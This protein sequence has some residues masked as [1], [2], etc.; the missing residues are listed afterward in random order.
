VTF[1]HVL[2]MCP[3]SPS[4]LR[5][6]TVSAIVPFS[7]KIHPPV[8]PTGTHLQ[9]GPAL[10]SHPSPKCMLMVQGG[11]PGI[12]DMFIWHFNQINLHYSLF[13]H[14]PGP[15]LFSSSQCIVSCCLHT[16]TPCFNIFTL[17]PSPASMAPQAAT[18][19]SRSLFHVMYVFLSIFI[20][21]G[22]HI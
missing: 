22:F 4:C 13:L 3:H 17:L 18:I 2:T 7:Y 12:S 1:T 6:I 11:F 20:L 8:P 5:T 10:P 14:R 16:Q 19:Q 9:T 15:L 21:Y